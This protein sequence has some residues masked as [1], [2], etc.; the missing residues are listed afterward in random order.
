[1]K[2]RPIIGILGAGKLGTTIGRIFID[3]GYPVLISNSKEAEEIALTIEVLVPN[4]IP[5]TNTEVTQQAEIIFLAL[6]LS[7]YHS[8]PR[9]YLKNK[10]VIDAMNYWCQVDGLD[11]IPHDSSLSS[12]QMIQDY[13]S[14]SIVIKAF[15]H[16]SY[17]DL[18]VESFAD[19]TKVIALAGDNQEAKEKV[20]MLIKDTGFYPLD[21]GSLTN[22]SVL[23][24]GSNLFGANL[25]KS[26]FLA[27][28]EK[29][30]ENK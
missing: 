30:T 9:E 5:L 16:M 12:S 10:L 13:L 17:H 27:I 15:N 29:L 19:N 11:R 24:P 3:A 28:L 18:E 7:K 25:V 21:V 2:N 23:E 8:I 22:S 4:A 14:E 1:M 6:P 26:E 20:A